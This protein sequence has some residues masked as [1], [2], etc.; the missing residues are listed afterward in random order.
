MITQHLHKEFTMSKETQQKFVGYLIK[1]KTNKMF[2]AGFATQKV[3]PRWSSNID[4]ALI[5][6]TLDQLEYLFTKELKQEADVFELYAAK[7]ESKTKVTKITSKTKVSQVAA[8]PAVKATKAKPAAKKPV[9]K[10]VAKKPAAKKK[11]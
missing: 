5:I 11:R 10:P 7:V 6:G 2:F 9:K 8:R 1:H 4:A 3:F